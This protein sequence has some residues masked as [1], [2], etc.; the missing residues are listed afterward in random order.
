M[1]RKTFDGVKAKNSNRDGPQNGRNSIPVS[2]LE[3][4]IEAKTKPKTQ[5]TWGKERGKD[6]C[7]KVMYTIGVNFIDGMKA[8]SEKRKG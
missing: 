5:K 2:S 7:I 6:R 4:N 3:A 1:E 8:Q